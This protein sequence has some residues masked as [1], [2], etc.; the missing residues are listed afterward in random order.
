MLQDLRYGVRL[1]LK[2]PGFTFIAVFTLA[3]GICGVTTQFSVVD[4]ALLRGLPFPE[5]DRLVRVTMRDPNWPPE[6][7]FSL[8]AA[9][10][11]EIAPKQQSFEDLAQY[12]FA[13]SF[14]VIIHDTPQR[15][16]GAHVT[17]NFFSVLGVSPALG[18]D[19]TE[20]DNQP[21]V[22]RVTIISDALWQSEFGGD[23]NILGRKLRL[24]GR[25]ATVIGVMPPG[26]Q[27]PRDQLWMPI[28]NE[29]TSFQERPGGGGANVL[30]RL[31]PGVT[32]TQA[33]SEVEVYLRALAEEYP[34][35]NGRYT[36]ARIEPLLSGFVAQPTRLLLITMFGAVIAVILIACANVM[37]MQFSRATVRSRELAIRA[38]LGASRR[39]LVRQ[40][41]V[42][43][44]V[45]AG[46]GGAAGA[47]LASWAIGLFSGVMGRLPTQALPSWMLF[48]IDGRALGFTVA[49]T[50]FSVILS[51]LL[52]ALAASRASLLDALNENA[53]GHTSRF[54]HRF[55]GGL[56]VGQIA[57]TCALLICSLL[58]IKSITNQFALNF[59]FDLD[60]V[61]AGRMNFEA[62]Y[63][64]DAE[65]RAAFQR[66]L[67]HLRSN[68]QFTHA[69]FTSRR[70]MMTTETFHG[71]IEG[72]TYARPEDRLESWLEFV[73]DG[74]FATLGL[75]P[76]AGREFEPGD[77]GD[78]RFVVL[79]NESFA[80][81]HF[82]S[83]SP[84]GHR[85]RAREGDT[86]RTIIGVV[87]DT[88]MQGP[89]EQKRDG[90]AVFVPTEALPLSYLT[91][92]VRGHEPAG[93]L[94]EPLR[95]EL[96]KIEPNLAIYV[97]ETPKIHLNNAL[98]QSR[99]VASLFAVFGGVAVVLA[100]IGLYGVMSFAVSRRI[101][102]FGIRLALG[103]QRRDIMVMVL[104][105]GISQL[106]LGAVLGVGLTLVFMQLGGAAVS[107]FLYGVNPHDP[108]IYAGVLAL[109]AIATMTACFVP[110]RRA[111]NL[112]PMVALRRE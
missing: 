23:P 54:V 93:R 44:L 88:L 99:S 112:D 105:K 58:L 111:T 57:L 56:V 10:V 61:L 75:T 71:Q 76:I 30:G 55:T 9:D 20:S 6:R 104:S 40:M 22:E 66:I 45:L 25:P 35:T 86:W 17:S 69:A 32:L 19:F 89:L 92:V 7:V 53:R 101:H 79:V 16:S 38:A 34:Q 37:N 85:L 27:F 21:G 31:K 91:L 41:L 72:R 80:Q 82:G 96:A 100:A 74:Y 47:M 84:L 26:F 24:N 110:A 4:A 77:T 52:P 81:K 65:R 98:A 90:S 15:L 97:V 59:G 18:R 106:A 42:E 43:S 68:P 62:E 33:T 28:F 95:R 51:G 36:E 39:R 64:T 2:N 109:L 60:S 13:G 87:P 29:Y 107:S 1:L 8:A 67:N 102:E 14:I 94:S 48:K 83:E 11:L 3:L 46:I 103:A 70:N 108:W 12:L 49:A 78:R 63:R 5:Q 50:A 73:S